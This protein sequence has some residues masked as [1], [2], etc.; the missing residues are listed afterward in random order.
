M[1]NLE[2]LLRGA[3]FSRNSDF[4]SVLEEKLREWM[5]EEIAEDLLLVA[6]GQGREDVPPPPDGPVPR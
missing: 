1:N 2:N 5:N 4:K 3:D 6:G